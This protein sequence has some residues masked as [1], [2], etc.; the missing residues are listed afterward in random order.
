MESGS[1][2]LRQ[3]CPEHT[4]Y[5]KWLPVCRLPGSHCSLSN[6]ILSER[7]CVQSRAGVRGCYN[8]S[9]TSL[10][11]CSSIDSSSLI[12]CMRRSTSFNMEFPPFDLALKKPRLFS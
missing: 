7:E 2:L 4:I 8:F 9:S 1:Q 5:H 6:G 10:I 3:W 11:F 12:F